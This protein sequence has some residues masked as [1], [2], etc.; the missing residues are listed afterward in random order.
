MQTQLRHVGSSSLIRDQT[1]APCIGS[2]SHW[3]TRE[4]LRVSLLVLAFDATDGPPGPTLP[5]SEPTFGKLG[6]SDL[7]KWGLDAPTS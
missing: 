4:V 3:T 2:L 1:Q 6:S 7:S 5:P